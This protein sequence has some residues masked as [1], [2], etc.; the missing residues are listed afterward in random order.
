MGFDSAQN[1]RLHKSKHKLMHVFLLTYT[2]QSLAIELL[3]KTD[4]LTKVGGT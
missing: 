3:H 1:E 4:Y 2:T